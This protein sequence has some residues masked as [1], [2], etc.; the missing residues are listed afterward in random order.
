MNRNR[1]PPNR[2]RT[3]GSGGLVQVMRTFSLTGAGFMGVAAAATN[4]H[5]NR[6]VL[7]V[8]AGVLLLCYV[9]FRAAGRPTN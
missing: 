2:A 5:N 1:N 6:P 9:L 7:G 3:S 8:V 4:D